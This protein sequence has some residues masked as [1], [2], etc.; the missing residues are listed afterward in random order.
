MA[1]TLEVEFR[2]TREEV[3]NDRRNDR[4]SATLRDRLGK[5]VKRTLFGIGLVLILAVGGLYFFAQ[6][7]SYESTDDAFVDGHITNV[8]PKIAGRIDKVFIDDNQLLKK[9]DPVVE[10]DPRDYHAQLKQKQAALDSTKAQAV[11]AQ[12]GVEQQIA[13]VKSLQATLDQDKA[14]QRSSEA[15]ADQTADD[16][17]RQ[18]DLYN[19]RVVSIQ[20]LIR[21]QDSNR[22][23]QANVDSAK[24]K[25]LSAE[26]QIS[27]GQAE[28]RTFAALLQ[29]VLAQQ[30]ENEANVE[31]AELN[32]SYTKV[33]APESGRVTRKS[34]EPGD[35]VQVGQ[36][37]LALIPSNIW[38]TANFKENQLRLMRPGQPVEIEVDA[39]GGKKFKGH[40]DSI[41]MGSGAAFSLLPPE[42][43][44]GNYVKVVQRV[45]VK[46]RFDSIP[47]VGLPL[48]PGESVVPTI[49]VQ[50][51]HYS[52]PQLVIAAASTGTGILAV[53]WW[54]TRPPKA[55]KEA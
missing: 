3:S 44:T 18:Q 26:A 39:L 25:V 20:D 17:R 32:D 48:G 37:L 46:I 31:T 42:N 29:Y 28:V 7:A 49:K 9:G 12:A 13:R 10:I 51:F 55:K 33:F 8:A 30:Q 4:G 36:N 52:L 19:H 43:A 22:S 21:S 1:Q 15:Q 24:M 54:G 35:Y 2:K 16:L 38:V 14:D 40:I 41:Q 45:P 50:D 23:A 11:A 27:A 53:L 5:R 6:T 34:V 47:D